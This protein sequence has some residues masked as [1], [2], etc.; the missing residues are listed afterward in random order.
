MHRCAVRPD[1]DAPNEN[2]VVRLSGSNYVSLNP[3]F[4]EPVDEAGG[5]LMGS[6]SWEFELANPKTISGGSNST[7]GWLMCG[8]DWGTY[9]RPTR[10]SRPCIQ[11][12]SFSAANLVPISG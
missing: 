3:Y 11:S 8:N 6:N 4:T 9:R 10:H 7:H 1:T 12:G 2:F 5:T